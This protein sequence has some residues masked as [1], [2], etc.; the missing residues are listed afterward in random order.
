MADDNK[1]AVYREVVADLFATDR[2]GAVERAC[3]SARLQ[4][5]GDNAR[6]EIREGHPGSC[7]QMLIRWR[8]YEPV[9]ARA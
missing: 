8:V 7:D 3:A 1:P 6:V 5:A 2:L 4:G 9:N